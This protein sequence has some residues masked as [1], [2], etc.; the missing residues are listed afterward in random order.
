[1]EQRSGKKILQRIIEGIIA[2]ALVLVFFAILIMVFNFVFPE[3]SGLHFIFN[4]STDEQQKTTRRESEL[5]VTQGEGADLI[6][7]DEDW[8]AT[9]VQA[10]NS[11]KSK[12]AN[13]IAWRRARKGMQ[14]SNLDAVQTLES[15]SATIRFD[16][17]N[18]ID[19]GENSL[20]VIRRLEKDLLFKEKRSFM[21]VVDG[22]LRGR[23]V[24]GD[25]SDVYLEIET[26]NAVARLQ[27]NPDDQQGIEFKV[28]VL[29]DAASSVTIYSGQG[30]VE[31]QG[32]TVFLG[33]NQITRIEG[34][35]APTEPVTL[36][37]PATM[38]TPKH[39]TTFPYRS[40]PPRVKISWSQQAG[41][42]RYH[43]LLAKDEA[44]TQ[45]LVDK[46]LKRTEFTH[47][48]LREGDYFW[49]ISSLN[50]AGEGPF[51]PAR[52]FSLQ[53]DRLPPELI[54]N[55]P[56]EMVEQPVVDIAGES[57]PDATIYV[58]GQVV[59]VEPDGS[60]QHKLH[61]NPGIN[62]VVV[63]AIDTA[64]N[65]SYQSQMINGKY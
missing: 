42:A 17:K 2:I 58:V 44:F 30:E 15:S 11:V 59:T 45:I 49:K 25:Q 38:L 22:E 56:P 14:L 35:L 52:Q 9:L 39:R 24:G 57:E 7:G 1:M 60:F 29:E 23:I 21:V 46:I 8:A 28:N 20:I 48:N 62:I 34:E 19:L 41:S 65:V 32:E 4:Q 54:V 37:S 50:S 43:L 12:K 51:S 6:F 16:T 61:L 10:R 27:S 55:F 40:L 63:E 26:P 31:A 3:G 47:G 53:H 18:Y 13:D 64:G 5:K 36:Q 33:K